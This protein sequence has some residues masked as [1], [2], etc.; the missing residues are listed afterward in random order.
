VPSSAAFNVDIYGGDLVSRVAEELRTHVLLMIE[1][2]V[3]QIDQAA[4]KTRQLLA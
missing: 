4:L 3:R 2:H 1:Q